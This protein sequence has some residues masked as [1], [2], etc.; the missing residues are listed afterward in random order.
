MVK[1]TSNLALAPVSIPASPPAS[2][3]G[4]PLSRDWIG[5]DAWLLPPLPQSKAERAIR[6]ISTAS[7]PIALTLTCAG[8][9]ALAFG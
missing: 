2:R 6:L 5:Y 4:D 1:A 9:L 7:G 3:A 8:L